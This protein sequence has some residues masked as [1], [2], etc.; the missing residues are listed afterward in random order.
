MA[1]LH[2]NMLHLKKWGYQIT[3]QLLFEGLFGDAEKTQA[4]CLNDGGGAYRSNQKL[5]QNYATLCN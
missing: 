1:G 3:F 4:V 2:Y 5:K